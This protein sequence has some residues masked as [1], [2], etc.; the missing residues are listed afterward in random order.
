MYLIVEL[1]KDFIMLVVLLLLLYVFSDY[2]GGYFV[3]V[4]DGIIK[5]VSYLF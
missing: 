3:F 1:V 4:G 5:Y 2:G